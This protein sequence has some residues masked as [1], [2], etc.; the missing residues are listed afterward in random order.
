MGADRRVPM[1]SAGR[2][3]RRRYRAPRRPVCCGQT[4]PAGEQRLPGG[5]LVHLGPLPPVVLHRQAPERGEGRCRLLEAIGGSRPAQEPAWT[6]VTTLSTVP[7][8]LPPS[9]RTRSR[10]DWAPRVYRERLEASAT[11]SHLREILSEGPRRYRRKAAARAPGRRDARSAS[12]PPPTRIPAGLASGQRALSTA[13]E[14][15]H[16]GAPPY[17]MPP[18]GPNATIMAAGRTEGIPANPA[19]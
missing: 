8:R 5:I 14:H 15:P 18:A 9:H 10:K 13:L 7:T 19:G 3:V 11:V 16:S 6:G 12:P 1:C 17:V 2:A 4:S